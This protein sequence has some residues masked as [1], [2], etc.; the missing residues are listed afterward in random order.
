MMRKTIVDDIHAV[1]VMADNL[2]SNG[3]SIFRAKLIRETEQY[4]VSWVID[5]EGLHNLERDKQPDGRDNSERAAG[6][7]T[8]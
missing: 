1:V 3:V 2:L 8:A 5:D 6:D 4:L 7:H